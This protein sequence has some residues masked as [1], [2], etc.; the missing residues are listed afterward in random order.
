MVIGT[1]GPLLSCLAWVNNPRFNFNCINLLP[2]STA[3]CVQ[4]RLPQESGLQGI[5]A[6][7]G[8]SNNAGAN[9]LVSGWVNLLFP[10]VHL[11]LGLETGISGM[12]LGSLRFVPLLH[13]AEMLN[14]AE[15]LC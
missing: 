10:L 9:R 1:L 11:L 13:L 15:V 6:L 5:W 2:T 4:R 14:C 12:G 8:N 3:D 7:G